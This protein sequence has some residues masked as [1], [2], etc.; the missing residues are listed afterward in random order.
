M[1]DESE[2]SE[3]DLAKRRGEQQDRERLGRACEFVNPEEEQR[4]ADEG[5]TADMEDWPEY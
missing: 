3:Q 1:S 4:L 2:R 5:L